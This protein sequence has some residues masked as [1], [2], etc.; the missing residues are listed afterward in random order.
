MKILVVSL[1]RLG[2]FLQIAPVV[3]GLKKRSPRARVDLLTFKQ[4]KALESILEFD[5]KWWTLDREDLQAGLGRADIPLLTSFDVLKEFIDQIENEKYDL[6]VNLTHTVFAGCL[7]GY[8]RSP[9]KIGLSIEAAQRARFYSPWFRYLDANARSK[10]PDIFNYTDIFAQACGVDLKSQSWPLRPTLS[11]L[12]EHRALKLRPST[13]VVCQLFTSDA[14]KNWSEEKWVQTLFRLQSLN[15]DWN[16]VLLGSPAEEPRITDVQKRLPFAQKGILTLDGA[17]AL[18]NRSQILITG[19]TSI[20]HL[21][22]ASPIRVLEL[23]LGSSD[24]ARTGIYKEDSLILQPQVQCGPC[25]HSEPCSQ[26]T[27]VCASGL[28]PE[29][30]VQAVLGLLQNDWD[31]LKNFA[32]KQPA[33]SFFRTRHLACGF[34][35]AEKLT[36]VES[37]NVVEEIIERSACKFWLNNEHQRDLAG[38]GSESVRLQEDLESLWQS[39]EPRPLLAH[40][41]FLE[42]D[43]LMSDTVPPTDS[44][45]GPRDNKKAA[46]VDLSPWRETDDLKNKNV[47]KKKLVRSLKSRLMEST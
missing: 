21:A 10:N 33:L 44:S 46:V 12:E 37:K 23:S 47:I 13:T 26:K 9:E 34:W 7:A 41:D 11:G 27:Q 3:A 39:A 32:L 42:Q 8:L 36:Q 16:F 1:L 30:V 20:K 4:V 2:D 35:F 25:P 45:S 28:Q 24:P 29:S 22:N 14:K 43:I 40:L 31:Q 6:I 38:Y 19:D 15:P 18:L 5:G 17:L